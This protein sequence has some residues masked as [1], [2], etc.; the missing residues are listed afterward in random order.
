MIAELKPALARK[1]RFSP[2]CE[3]RCAGREALARIKRERVELPAAG[4][5]ELHAT[6]EVFAPKLFPILS[7]IAIWWKN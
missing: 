5:R 6:R 4:G 1:Q 3:S 2:L 7:G